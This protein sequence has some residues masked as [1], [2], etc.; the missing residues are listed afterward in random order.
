MVGNYPN[1]EKSP[2]SFKEQMSHNLRFFRFNH[3]TSI[4]TS[5][6]LENSLTIDE[7]FSDRPSPEDEDADHHLLAG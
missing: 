2:S 6:G 5:E 1:P 7:F 4:E 3:K